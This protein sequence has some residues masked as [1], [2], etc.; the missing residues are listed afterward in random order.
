MGIRLDDISFLVVDDNDN[1]RRL[2][3]LILR[4]LGARAVRE[5]HDGKDAIERMK[6]ALPDILITDWLMAPMDGA[7]LTR[8]IRKSPQS[9]YIYMPI[10]MVTGFA[11]R[12]KVFAA[13]DA[14]VTEFL[15]K[16]LS[17]TALYSRIHTIIERPRP[18]VRIGAFFG[19]DRRRH[20]SEWTAEDRRHHAA[21]EHKLAMS[22]IPMSQSQI[23]NL[24]NP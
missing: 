14:G 2:V 19:P 3:R 5:A 16:P 7:T 1:M 15:I 10:I 22:D 17:A 21:L 8:F 9:P 24:F 12:D 11:D 18:F 20:K 13:R 6:D 23:N 4:S